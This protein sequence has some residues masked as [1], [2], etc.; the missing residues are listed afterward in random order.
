[1]RPAV[2]FARLFKTGTPT[3]DNFLARVFGMFSEEPIRIWCR[4]ETSPFI[5]L[6]RPSIRRP[7]ETRGMAVDFALRSKVSGKVYV[8]EL[9]CE[10]ALAN[11][12]YLAPTS[13]SQVQRHLNETG[14]EAFRRFVDCAKNA[15]SYQVF[16]E[17][18]PIEPVG[19][20]P[21]EISNRPTADRFL[22]G[23][24]EFR[25]VAQWPLRIDDQMNVIGHEDIGPQC[26][27]KFASRTFDC[28][29]QPF[30][31]PV[32]FQERKTNGSRLC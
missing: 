20:F 15:T 1:M 3:R 7:G 25:S 29:S 10:L 4:S 21:F 18:N 28:I 26:I 30:A 13:A 19:R 23:F 12:S 22:Y 6:G 32:F 24:Q 14:K 16:V 11:Y 31:R 27:L 9:K 8:A 5:D 2:E 17:A